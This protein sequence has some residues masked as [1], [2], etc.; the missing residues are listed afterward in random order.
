MTRRRARGP[1]AAVRDAWLTLADW[2]GDAG[3]GRM[4]AETPAR[5]ARRVGGHFPAAAEPL[6]GLTASFVAAEY[7]KAGPSADV[8]ALAR[9]QAAQAR[10]AVADE[11]GWARR[12]RAALS[13]GSLVGGGGGR[14]GGRRAGT[15]RWGRRRRPGRTE[16]V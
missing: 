2:L 12:L 7:G 4:A 1:R 10:K 9:E 13:L 6:D 14:M 11:L 15:G 8:A 16:A 5:W 3:Y